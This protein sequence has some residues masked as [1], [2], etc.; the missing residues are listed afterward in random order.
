MKPQD[1][2][3][4]ALDVTDRDEA[5]RIAAALKGVPWAIKVNWP[6]VLGAGPDIITELAGLARVIC[7]FKVADIPFTNDLIAREAF[8]RGASGLIVHAF[9]G[10][11][12][13]A[14]C[15]EAAAGSKAEAPA[16]AE[17]KIYVVTEMSHPGGEAFTQPNADALC[18]LAVEGGAHGVIAPATRPERLTHIRGQVG[19]LEI[20]SP[21]V[22]AQGGTARTAIEAGATR[23]I[24]GRAITRADDPAA[25]AREILAGLE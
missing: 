25:A 15:V 14:A 6:L 10:A 2:L 1:R 12:S 13:I 3:I 7:D 22:G 20:L 9:T 8:R 16:G 17:R 11:D 5:I 4:V 19:E 24:V 18:R 23:V 21:G